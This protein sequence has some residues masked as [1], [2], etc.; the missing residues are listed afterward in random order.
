MQAIFVLDNGQCFIV[1]GVGR[2]FHFHEALTDEEKEL[3]ELSFAQF[4]CGQEEW[5][6]EHC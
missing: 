5:D 6:D 1:K 4:A 3:A 2:G